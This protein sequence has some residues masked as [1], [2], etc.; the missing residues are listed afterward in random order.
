MAQQILTSL[1][2]HPDAW[3]RV[4]TILEYAGNQQTKVSN[5]KVHR[6]SFIHQLSV[7]IKQVIIR[8]NIVCLRGWHGQPESFCD[9]F[10]FEKMIAEWAMGIIYDWLHCLTFNIRTH[11]KKLFQQQ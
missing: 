10:V 1:K 9:V 6:V 3:T 8:K 7:E 11:L 2:D 4:D 5:G